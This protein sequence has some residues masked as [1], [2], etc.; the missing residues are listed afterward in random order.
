MLRIVADFARLSSA[1]NPFNQ[2]ESLPSQEVCVQ[3]S[4]NLPLL[5]TVSV[6]STDEITGEMEIVWTKPRLPD[7]DTVLY[8]GPYRYRLL[9][10]PGLGT[11]NWVPVAGGDFSAPTFAAANDTFVRFDAPL[12][13]D[14]TPIPIRSNSILAPV[15]NY[16]ERLLQLLRFS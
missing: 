8:P 4:R 13:H 16:W 1:G 11:A 12:I 7:L 6:E 14:L 10:S 15:L 3:L 5:T 9:R 2:V